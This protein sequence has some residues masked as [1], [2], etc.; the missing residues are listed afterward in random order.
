MLPARQTA[1]P[2]PACSHRE[3]VNFSRH[4]VKRIPPSP[5]KTV[6]ATLEFPPVLSFRFSALPLPFHIKK[7]PG[8]TA[9]AGICLP[10]ISSRAR[11][12]MAAI[13]SVFPSV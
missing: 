12:V 6:D 4:A 9:Y 10:G 2:S 11:R 7:Q 5:E 3:T 1:Y 8:L 13:S